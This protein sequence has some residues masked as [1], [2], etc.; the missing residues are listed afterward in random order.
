MEND[1]RLSRSASVPTTPAEAPPCVSNAKHEFMAGSVPHADSPQRP[2]Q[3]TIERTVEWH[4]TDAAGHHHHSSILRWVEAA[5]TRLH[6]ALGTTCLY[7]VAPRVRYEANYLA[8]LWF[9]DRVTVCLWPDR[10][11]TSSLHYGFQVSRG[12]EVASTG[13]MSVV[14]FDPDAGRATHWP[15]ELRRTL[16]EAIAP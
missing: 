12:S 15:S 2:I 6:E 3:V 11:G 5:E 14:H 16:V 10:V 4:D 13:S 9:R 8:R 1:W 7:G